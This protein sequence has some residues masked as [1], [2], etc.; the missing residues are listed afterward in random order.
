MTSKSDIQRLL[1]D[2]RKLCASFA[3]AAL[4]FLPFAAFAEVVRN[5]DF[6]DGSTSIASHPH[7]NPSGTSR[8]S[9]P[10]SPE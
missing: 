2:M 5:V 10:P 8:G 1:L 7:L 9:W 4:A 3:L 6:E